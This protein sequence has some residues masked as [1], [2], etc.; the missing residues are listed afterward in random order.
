[1]MMIEMIKRMRIEDRFLTFVRNDRESGM[2]E[3]VILLG[4]QKVSF[5][6]QREISRARS[7]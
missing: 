2:T 3:N 1:M 7:R 4:C 6:T 5:R